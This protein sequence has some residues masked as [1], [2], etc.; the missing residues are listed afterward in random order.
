MRPWFAPSSCTAWLHL[1]ST[2]RWSWICCIVVWTWSWSNLRL[3]H[4]SVDSPDNEVR[5]CIPWLA[6]KEVHLF[7]SDVPLCVANSAIGSHFTQSSC[8]WLTIT[9]RHC[10][11]LAFI[12]SVWPS[13]WRWN[14]ANILRSIPK[15]LHIWLQTFGANWDPL[16]EIIVNG[17]QSKHKSAKNISVRAL[18]LRR[19]RC[20]PSEASETPGWRI[21]PRPA[22]IQRI[23]FH[24]ALWSVFHLF[25]SFGRSPILNDHSGVVANCDHTS[26]W[27]D[28]VSACIGIARRWVTLRKSLLAFFLPASKL[29]FSLYRF[30]TS[31][32]VARSMWLLTI[33][34]SF[35]PSPVLLVV[36]ISGMKCA[37]PTIFP[38]LKTCKATAASALLTCTI[39]E[40]GSKLPEFSGIVV[41]TRAN[42]YS[43]KAPSSF[44]SL[45]FNS[46]CSWHG[47]H[48]LSAP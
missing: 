26:E 7:V 25:F 14:A 17:C 27:V 20:T 1:I 40:M 46:R 22:S 29:Q 42:Q 31:F 44:R 41:S 33:H 15:Q 48:P 39:F 9:Q 8:W 36:A 38:T 45:M 43:T 19:S 30:Y 34:H 4:C 5:Q 23:A 12:L 3:S 16:S 10:S 47:I 2:E 24:I 18:W 35:R 32:E 21:T 37:Q 28:W 6:K 13:F 11:I